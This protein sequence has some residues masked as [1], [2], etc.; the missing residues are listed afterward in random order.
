[1]TVH[2][3][4]ARVERQLARL[5]AAQARA[6][7]PTGP[8]CALCD[9]RPDPTAPAWTPGG[10]V[11]VDGPGGIMLCALTCDVVRF[12]A[13]DLA[14]DASWYPCR[15][16]TTPEGCP[17]RPRP[18]TPGW[19]GTC[20]RCFGLDRA[21]RERLWAA[22]LRVLVDVTRADRRWMAVW[23]AVHVAPDEVR[24]TAA[25]LRA[26]GLGAGVG[27]P[28]VPPDD[29]RTVAEA[30]A[31][32][33]WAWV[34][35]R[36]RLAVVQACRP[37]LLPVLRVVSRWGAELGRD[38]TG[39]AAW[40]ETT[41]LRGLIGRLLGLADGDGAAGWEAGCEREGLD[42]TPGR[43]QVCQ[44]HLLAALDRPLPPA[45]TAALAEPDP[46]ASCGPIR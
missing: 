17:Y 14:E 22:F 33:T 23:W 41:L 36:I 11:L 27:P 44:Q 8:A 13:H 12:V 29:P 15:N 35:E 25:H 9:R 26:Y 40:L 3:R 46:A 7:A 30:Q 28:L 2:A 4:L 6:Q 5:A 37:L 16:D 1:M 42:L 39:D 34:L 24:C 19:S 38:A 10:G 32:E 20:R 18:G 21:R 31:L 43:R 45:L